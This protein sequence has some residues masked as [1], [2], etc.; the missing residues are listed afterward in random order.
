LNPHEVTAVVDHSNVPG[1]PSSVLA[2]HRRGQCLLIIPV[3]A[4]GIRADVGVIHR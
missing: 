3:P 2:G 1:E 4:R